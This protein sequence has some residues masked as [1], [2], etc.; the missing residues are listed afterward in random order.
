[1]PCSRARIKP[2]PYFKYCMLSIFSVGGAL[3]VG[4]TLLAELVPSISRTR[5]IG[6]LVACWPLGGIYSAVLAW[7][8]L[9]TTGKLISYIV[10][11][12]L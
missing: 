9:P 1:M 3:P 5:W 8:F 11:K 6:S 7:C 2:A 12:C 4:S 10:L